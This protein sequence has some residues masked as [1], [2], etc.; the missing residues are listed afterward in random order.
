MEKDTKIQR[1]REK[2]GDNEKSREGKKQ[3]REKVR[4]ERRDCI[5]INEL[6]VNIAFR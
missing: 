5:I 3:E 2:R 6:A 1:D 4:A